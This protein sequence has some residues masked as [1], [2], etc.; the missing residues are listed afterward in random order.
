MS[1]WMCFSVCF[2]LSDDDSTTLAMVEV[3]WSLIFQLKRSD[4]H[5]CTK[6]CVCLSSAYHSCRVVV[7]RRINLTVAQWQQNKMG[8][9]QEKA[10]NV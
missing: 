4:R 5:H 7:D 2:P 1:L 10:L 6:G 9:S 8:R 3:K